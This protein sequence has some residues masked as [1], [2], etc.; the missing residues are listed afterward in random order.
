MPKFAQAIEKFNLDEPSTYTAFAV[1]LTTIGVSIPEPVISSTSFILS[2]IF[3]MFGWI[4]S[5]KGKQK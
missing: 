5:E 1:G 4:K 3:S 2:G